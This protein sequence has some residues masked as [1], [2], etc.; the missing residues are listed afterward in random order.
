MEKSVP[1]KLEQLGSAQTIEDVSIVPKIYVI[2]LYALAFEYALG[3]RSSAGDIVSLKSEDLA[4]SESGSNPISMTAQA[5][6]EDV[7]I[8]NN[9]EYLRI[10][11]KI[12]TIIPLKKG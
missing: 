4:I 1:I 9:K 10:N 7:K 8:I 5:K 11:L 2:S 12:I 3:P 6:K